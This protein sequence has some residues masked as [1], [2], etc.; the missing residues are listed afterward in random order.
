MAATSKQEQ[1]GPASARISTP[2][3]ALKHMVIPLKEKE[4]KISISKTNPGCFE[5]N[6]NG[7][8]QGTQIGPGFDLLI[9]QSAIEFRPQEIKIDNTRVPLQTEM[10]PSR[11]QPTQQRTHDNPQEPQRQITS[12]RKVLLQNRPTAIQTTTENNRTA[13]KATIDNFS[14]QWAL[15]IQ[16]PEIFSH[17]I[18]RF[19]KV[20]PRH[21]WCHDYSFA[22]RDRFH[23]AIHSPLQVCR[24]PREGNES[25]KVAQ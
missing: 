24:E 25:R 15:Q 10:P 9:T 14:K 23:T 8:E 22:F 4:V 3:D 13:K 16:A 12:S 20:G 19:G 11:E 17:S 7:E 5:L 2:F 21:N 1:T 18:W 6:I